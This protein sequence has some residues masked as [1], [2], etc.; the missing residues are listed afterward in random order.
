MRSALLVAALAALALPDVAA[1]R[2][3]RRPAHTALRADRRGDVRDR[4]EDGCDRQEDGR[5]RRGTI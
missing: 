3:V 4:R 5:D 1:A 2:H